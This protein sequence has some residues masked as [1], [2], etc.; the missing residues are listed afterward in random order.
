MKAFWQ[1]WWFSLFAALL[2]L[3][4]V[5]G[6]LWQR[7]RRFKDLLVLR[8]KISRD[9]HDEIGSTLS[10]INI[11]SK[12]SQKNLD[13]DVS[14]A[15]GLLQK[16]TEQS[17]SIQQSISDIVWSISPDNDKMESLVIRMREYLGQTA[18]PKNMQV[19][20]LTD[21]SIFR[22]S[23]STLQRQDV[24]LIFKEAANN[25][26]KYSQG[27]KLEVRLGKEN[28]HLKLTIQDDGIGFETGKLTSSNGI[29]NMKNRSIELKGNL[30]ILSAPGQG[31]RVELICP[32]T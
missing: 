6:I 26:V 3:S 15:S 20:F 17:E 32:V 14:K 11:L 22:L 25:A 10:S 29:K 28:N 30:K 8:T 13:K 4:I 31:T 1:T 19:E 21:E 5:A 23:L 27:R 18:E 2:V 16:I 12:V 7:F 24:F 9:L